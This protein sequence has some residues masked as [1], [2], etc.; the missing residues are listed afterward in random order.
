MLEVDL[1]ASPLT[2]RFFVD[3]KEHRDFVTHIPPSI[4]FAVC[5]IILLL[6]LTLLQISSTDK[7]DSCTLSLREVAECAGRGLR[8][9]RSFTWGGNWKEEEKN[10]LLGELTKKQQQ[11]IPVLARY[12]ATPFPRAD[13]PLVPDCFSLHWLVSSISCSVS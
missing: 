7:G 1:D 3:D 2:L 13:F 11:A 10:R 8:N 4:T 5:I 12:R 6:P 9:S